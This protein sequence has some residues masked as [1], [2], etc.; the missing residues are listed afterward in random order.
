MLLT[1]V[2][3]LL[4]I[5]LSVYLAER[6]L[7]QASKSFH[8]S[9]H[10][11]EILTTAEELRN[12]CNQL[13]F[14]SYLLAEGK[15]DK[16]LLTN[17]YQHKQNVL[18]LLKRL[19]N[20]TADNYNQQ[21]KV[22][23][24]HLIIF[25]CLKTIKTAVDK[26]QTGNLHS[27]ELIRLEN[28]F[29]KSILNI[30]NVEY[31][32]LKIRSFQS[33]ASIQQTKSKVF[34]AFFVSLF[35]LF[36]ANVVIYSLLSKQNKILKE[37]GKLSALNNAIISKA[38]DPIITTNGKGIVLS[39]NPAAE[40]LF[41][42]KNEEI[43][44]KSLKML[45]TANDQ[46]K[47]ENDGFDNLLTNRTEFKDIKKDG[48]SIPLLISSAKINISD[49]Q[50]IISIILH[51]L[52]EYKA[53]EKE[54]H[55]LSRRLDLAT[56]IAQMAVWE[57][58]VKTNELTLLRHLFSDFE[59]EKTPKNLLK[60]LQSHITQEEQDK[61]KTQ[62]KQAFN[63]KKKL[64]DLEFLFNKNPDDIRYLKNRALIEYDKKGSP[65][66]LIGVTWDVTDLKMATEIQRQAKQ[67][68]EEANQ[69]KSHFL[70]N[71]SHEI[72]TPLNAIIGL[73]LLLR[74]TPLNE[75]QRDYVAK[76]HLS[77]TSLL[78]IINEILDFSKIE[79]G[80]LRI[81][82]TKFNLDLILN[83]LAKIIYLKAREKGLELI[84]HQDIKIP[85]TL[86]GDPL[87]ISQILTN[88]ISNAIKFTE[89]GQIVVSAKLVRQT[90][91]LATLQFSISDTGIGIPEEQLN[92][93]FQPFM[94]AD[95][96]TARKYGGTGLGLSICKQLVEMMDGRI[97]AE[98]ILNKGSIF[99]FE[100][101][102]PY[103]KVKDKEFYQ[104]PVELQ[105]LRILIVDDVPEI[106][107][108]LQEQLEIFSKNST[109]VG[110]GKEAITEL[111]NALITGKKLYDL[112]ILD[113]RL[114]DSNGLEVAK[115]I[116]ADAQIL[117]KPKII[118][119]SAYIDKDYLLKEKNYFDAF[120]T[121]PFTLSVL[122]NTILEVFSK[123]I[124][125]EIGSSAMVNIYPKG[126]DQIRGAKILIA[127]DNELNQQVIKEL[128]ENEG[129]FVTIAEDGEKAIEFVFQETDIFDLIL[130]DIH[131][132]GVNGF[133]A[134]QAIRKNKN[135]SEVPVIALTADLTSNIQRQIKE[136]GLND[137]I[138]KPIDPD[139]LFIKLIQWIK[140]LKREI[141]Q[142]Q[143]T[144][145]ERESAIRAILSS[146]P[147]LDYSEGLRRLNYNY[148]LYSELIIKFRQNNLDFSQKLKTLLKNREIE[149]F[150]RTVHTLKSTA[151]NLGFN[152]IQNVATELESATRNMNLNQIQDLMQKA[153]FEIKR[154]L[155]TLQP[156]ILQLKNYI[157]SSVGPS[158]SRDEVKKELKDSLK[159]LQDYD[160][161]AKEK[162]KRLILSI[163]NLGFPQQAE[164]LLGYIESYQFD[165]AAE[166]VK[167][168]LDLIESNEV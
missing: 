64:I 127:E 89:Q 43:I 65:K 106:R 158:L 118:L 137:F 146:I 155:E 38:L 71:M 25:K 4:G 101:S 60:S 49:E 26:S 57:W 7:N 133:E 77:A 139:E 33:T 2:L 27:P 99:Y 110:T 134:T 148:Q 84:F 83:R 168:I 166:I 62:I 107:Q 147:G 130:M 8:S 140:P 55:K 53:K 131:M 32:L 128:L 74:Q 117:K 156:Y 93:L 35:I 126:F 164:T 150:H 13:D 142:K 129:F 59:T 48:T 86:F 144:S 111:K 151:G 68:A 78:S 165:E 167:N 76:I 90:E 98:S 154:T 157:Q 121:K 50:S 18:L 102:F 161:R 149:E 103:E 63:Q 47:F 135:Y 120:L 162:I 100:L 114:P 20:L 143:I 58:D 56:E 22:K 40:T 96:S 72:R 28:K 109:T 29:K 17:F 112:V 113:W 6:S 24:L 152:S 11:F 67:A 51:D 119:I 81:E 41:D 94:Q 12:A 61:I 160:A 45:L 145:D 73:N 108:T 79:A 70:A 87:R 75:K 105:N 44:G 34:L 9:E 54:I 30:K 92:H 85:P 15:R 16:T 153:E 125:H 97:W 23:D 82:K 122:F 52:S 1:I 31:T 10:S 46:E 163:K 141:F 39:F 69:A 19:E 88:M 136:K 132:P 138:S 36:L 95:I 116:L 14:L 123:E 3:P 124:Q 115:K 66:L 91:N 80:K 159:L 104:P 37:K 5:S 21:K 42:Y